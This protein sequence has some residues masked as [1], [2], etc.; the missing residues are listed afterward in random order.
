MRTVSNV[1]ARIIL[2]VVGAL[3]IYAAALEIIAA[4]KVLNVPE[5]GWWNFANET[6]R[7]AMLVFLLAVVNAIIGLTALFA[8]IRGKRSF[9]L[10]FFSLILMITPVYTVV[11]QVQGGTFVA[12]WEHISKL[13]LEFL[14]PILYFVGCLLLVRNDKQ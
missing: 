11:T 9:W 6:A 1:I 2:L 12:D 3:I 4:V 13:I 8:G 10:F 7:N 14:T 5:T